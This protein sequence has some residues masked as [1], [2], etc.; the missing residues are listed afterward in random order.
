MRLGALHRENCL[1]MFR[2]HVV[3]YVLFDASLVNGIVHRVMGIIFLKRLISGEVLPVIQ[4]F[5]I[6]RPLETIGAP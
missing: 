2:F 5:F 6:F 3:L 4:F 1:L